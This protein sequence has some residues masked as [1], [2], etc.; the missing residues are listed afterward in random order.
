MFKSSKLERVN[1]PFIERPGWIG[2]KSLRIEKGSVSSNEE[3]SL[4]LPYSLYFK[5]LRMV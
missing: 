1:K 4:A 5:H 2:R 3:N